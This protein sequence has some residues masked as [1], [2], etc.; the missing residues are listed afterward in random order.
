MAPTG[1]ADPFARRRAA[2]GVLQILLAGPSAPIDEL[3]GAALAGYDGVLPVDSEAVG[4]AIQE[5]FLGR[6]QGIL[7]ERGH[8]YDTVDAVLAVSA[9]SPADA[10]ARCEALTR[11]REA[12]DDMTNLSIAFTRAKN[13][14][15]PDLG[16]ATDRSLM[17]AEE[18]ALADALDTTE[19]LL[20]EL[21]EQ[22]A[23]SAV[24]DSFAGLRGPIDAFF[25]AVMVMD[26]D[27]ALKTNRLRL[28]NRFVAQFSRF[29]DFSVL[30]G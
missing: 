7:R 4:S 3:I 19:A 23:Y 12:S 6:L 16:T 30:A 21:F 2:I 24:L 10:L 27:E 15:Q 28:L 9:N 1:S 8:A 22:A 17:A 11:F 14:A 29:A 13:L 5:F 20:G 18:V 26:P 25:E